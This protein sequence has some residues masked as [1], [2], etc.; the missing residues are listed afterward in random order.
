MRDI[1]VFGHFEY[2]SL[3]RDVLQSIRILCM[4]ACVSTHTHTHTHVMSLNLLSL[5]IYV[6]HAC[7]IRYCGN[8]DDF[9]CLGDE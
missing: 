4:R 8:V 6:M 1:E 3:C 7:V 5:S 9:S 2:I